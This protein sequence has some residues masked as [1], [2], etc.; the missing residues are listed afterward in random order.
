MVMDP[1]EII[2]LCKALRLEGGEESVVRM[3]KK[4]ILTESRN[5][6]LCLVGKVMGNNI[7][8]REASEG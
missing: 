1:R 6:N 7:I 5:I 2:R 3:C 4:T 8:N